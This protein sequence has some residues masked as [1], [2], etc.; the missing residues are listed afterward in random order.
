MYCWP[1]CT[2]HQPHHVPMPFKAVIAALGD[3]RSWWPCESFVWTHRIE[4]LRCSKLAAAMQLCCILSMACDVSHAL[5]QRPSLPERDMPHLLLRQQTLA[6]RCQPGRSP[7]ATAVSILILQPCKKCDDTASASMEWQNKGKCFT[8]THPE[9]HDVL[10]SNLLLQH[11]SDMGM[12]CWCVM[13][14]FMR[15]TGF[16]LLC[17]SAAAAPSQ[18]TQSANDC[19]CSN[20]TIPRRSTHDSE[21]PT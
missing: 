14:C 5:P 21:P 12:S 15:D 8:A 13:I 19:E 20:P 3:T 6:L 17:T 16:T 7:P 9:C 2:V 10:Y 11:C 4:Q 18:C 1:C